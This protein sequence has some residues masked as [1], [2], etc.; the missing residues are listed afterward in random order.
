MPSRIAA[1]ILG[2]MAFAG[3][4]ANA[5]SPVE[6]TLAFKRYD[7]AALCV[8]NGVIRSRADGGLAVDTPSSRAALREATA[9][10]AEIRFRYLGPTEQSKPLASGELRRQIGIKL[11]AQDTCNVLYAMW[12]IEPDSRLAVSVKRNPGKHTHA[13]CGAHGYRN[14][15]PY[16]DVALPP[17]RSGETHTLR[18]LLVGGDVTLMVDGRS[19]WAGTVGKEMVDFDGPVGFRTDNARFEFEFLAAALDPAIESRI[20]PGTLDHC[21]PSA[22]D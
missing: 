10:K 6:P 4:P 15:K 2:L 9:P 17:I 19:V 12:H 5:I 13:Q 16:Y 20:P 11:R 14:I 8:T 7:A 1:I 18:A 3:R 22:G 21:E